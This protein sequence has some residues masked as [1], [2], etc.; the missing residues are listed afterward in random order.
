MTHIKNSSIIVRTKDAKINIITTFVVE[1]LN[2]LLL[3]IEVIYDLSYH[4]HNFG[5]S[6][7]GHFEPK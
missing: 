6:F 1:K 2:V 3:V 5:Y 4:S 7:V